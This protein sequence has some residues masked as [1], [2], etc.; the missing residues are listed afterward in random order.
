MKRGL[1]FLA[2]AMVFAGVGQA[3]AAIIANWTFEVSVPATAGPHNAEVGSGEASGFHADS[4][5]VYSNPSGNGS[6][7]SF[8]S[9]FWSVGDYYQFKVSTIGMNSIKLTFDQASSNTGPRDFQV[10][11]SNDG[12]T[13]NNFG[14]VYTVLANASPNPTWNTTTPSSL[15]T[16]VFDLSSVTALDNQASI[17]IRLTDVSTV[18][19]NGGT[20]ATGG[21]DRVDNVIIEGTAAVPEP[22]SLAVLGI[23]AAALLRRRRK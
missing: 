18:S 1:V 19:A 13:F 15:Y 4:S 16:N 8:S 11:Y 17:W 23:G 6:L 12:T 22:A 2:S 3:N 10:Q 5:V 9:N 14:S 7:E 21:T 20:V